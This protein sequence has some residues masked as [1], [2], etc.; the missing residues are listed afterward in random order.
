[1]RPSPVIVKQK[2]EV[3]R[4]AGWTRSAQNVRGRPW[5]AGVNVQVMH[6]TKMSVV[7]RSRKL[8]TWHR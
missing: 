1:M 6:T 3:V 8:R 2:A 5:V 7:P 4:R